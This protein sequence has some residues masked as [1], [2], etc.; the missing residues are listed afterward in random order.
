MSD[1]NPSPK[2]SQEGKYAGLWIPLEILEDQD[3]TMTE[4][5]IFAMISALDSGKGFWMSNDA[6]AQRVSVSS[7]YASVCLSHLQK[8]GY[9][10]I[11]QP[12][13]GRRI[14]E[15]VD[16][17]ALRG[18]LSIDTQGS[19]N[20][21]P[22]LQ[23]SMSPS[24]RIKERRDRDTKG[25]SSSDDLLALMSGSLDQIFPWK[26]TPALLDAWADWIEYRKERKPRLT[27]STGKKQILFLAKNAR[28]EAQAIE[29]LERSIRNSWM[30]L[31]PLP[32]STQDD[33]KIRVNYKDGKD[34]LQ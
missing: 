18:S 8:K 17:L 28:D 12:P 6:L 15:T 2:A 20:P 14:V 25:G 19:L 5:I 13:G 7:N 21:E 31:F 32:G 22:P 3:L 34:D 9:I 29:I 24:E 11:H 1:P 30:G 16:R 33:K 10:K 26:Q 27:L 23:K 4:K